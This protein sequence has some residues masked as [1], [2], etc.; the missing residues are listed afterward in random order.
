LLRGLL[1]GARPGDGDLEGDPG[2]QQVYDAVRHQPDGDEQPR[3]ARGAL[4]AGLPD[5]V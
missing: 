3:E 4:V 2:D 5:H 1:A